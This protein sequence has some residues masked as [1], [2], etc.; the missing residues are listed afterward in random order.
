MESVEILAR[1]IKVLVFDQYGTIMD[2]QKGLT[3]GLR[4]KY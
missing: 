4:R 2:M 3:E 1:E